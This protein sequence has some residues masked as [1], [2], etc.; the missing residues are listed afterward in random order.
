MLTGFFK[1]KSLFSFLPRNFLRILW[2]VIAYL[3]FI[4]AICSL[5]IYWLVNLLGSINI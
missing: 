1:Q 2:Q 4:G 3:L 5:V